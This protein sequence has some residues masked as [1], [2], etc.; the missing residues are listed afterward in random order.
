M[1]L[2]NITFDQSEFMNCDGYKFLILSVEKQTSIENLLKVQIFPVVY[3]L[4][5]KYYAFTKDEMTSGVSQFDLNRI[6]AVLLSEL[7]KFNNIKQADVNKLFTTIADE[8]KSLMV[9]K[10][11]KINKDIGDHISSSINII[12]KQLS[13]R[14]GPLSNFISSFD[15]LKD[16]N[17][18]SSLALSNDVN[19]LKDLCVNIVQQ[20]SDLNSLKNNFFKEMSGF[21]ESAIRDLNNNLNAQ[22]NTFNINVTSA[23]TKLKSAVDSYAQSVDEINKNFNNRSERTEQVFV[24]ASNNIENT[25]KNTLVCYDN[26]TQSLDT[27]NNSFLTINSIANKNLLIYV[28]LSL[29]IVAFFMGIIVF[30]IFKKP[31]PKPKINYAKR[32]V[33]GY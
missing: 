7:T 21:V 8:T 5:N 6:T 27:F 16:I 32:S 9:S 33:Y 28:C 22:I 29:F 1:E 23:N 18:S 14:L 25:L 24:T 3:I 13:D 11:D 17:E 2:K 15:R 4:E 31:K 12:D 19:Q 10:V 26:M 20:T 30:L